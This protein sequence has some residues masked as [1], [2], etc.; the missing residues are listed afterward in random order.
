MSRREIQGHLQEIYGM[1]VSPTLI[2]NVTDPEG[3]VTLLNLTQ[4]AGQVQVDLHDDGG[5][6]RR[7]SQYRNPNCCVRVSRP[8]HEFMDAW[9]QQGPSTTSPSGSAINHK[10]WRIC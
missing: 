3:P 4:F 2:S 8:M 9:C 7:Y 6:Q 10:S 5:D 1:E